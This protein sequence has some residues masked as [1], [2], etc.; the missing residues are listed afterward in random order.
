MR[1]FSSISMAFV[2]A[3][4]GCSTVMEANRPAAVNLHKF[5]IDEKRFDV[6][7]NVGAPLASDK[8]G[9][10][11]CD[12]YKLYTHG[13]SDV[14]KGA[15]IVTEAAADVFTLGLFEVLATPGEAATKSKAHP[16]LFCYD[17]DGKLASVTEAGQL[18]AG[19]PSAT[20]SQATPSPTTTAAAAEPATAPAL[21]S[22]QKP[23]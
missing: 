12:V 18:V 6:V 15:I 5:Y 20:G 3:L 2:L 4:G 9:G 22:T 11:S 7:A 14:G 23:N 19:S 16:V 17:T 8:D 21:E 13:V 1:D 10:R